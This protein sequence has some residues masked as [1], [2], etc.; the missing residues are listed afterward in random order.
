M[1]NILKAAMA[2]SATVL[3]VAP[4]FAQ[5]NKP[6]G[7][8]VRAGLFL[9]Q[10][11]AKDFEGQNWFTA[12]AEYKLG[13]LKFNNTSST[14]YS[15]SFDYYGKG[16]L[17]SAPLLV[18]YVT[19]TES[20]YYSVGAGVAFTHQNF[21]G[22]SSS[23][24]EF[25]YQLSIGKDFVRSNTPLFVEFRYNGNNRTELNGFSLVGGVRF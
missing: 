25:A 11:R 3:L 16:S 4:A 5:Y 13:N 23:D 22:P 12:G 1:N 10:G 7:L 14:S 19:R 18:N 2:V 8:S 21:N 9:A 17:S 24:M 15:V 20:F 6:V